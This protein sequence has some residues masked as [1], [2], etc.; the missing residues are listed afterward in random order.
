MSL[1]SSIQ[2]EHPVS[3]VVLDKKDLEILKLLQENAKLSIRDIALKIHL[4]PTPTH[5]RIKRLEKEGV[6]KQYAAL[7][8]HRMVKKSIMAICNVTM[9][10]HNKKNAKAFIDSVSAFNEVIECYNISGQYDFMLKIVAESMED[11]H[12]FYVNKLSE[13]KGIGHMHSIFVMDVIKD[14]HQVI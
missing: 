4:S 1:K 10:E 14:T 11:Y 6:I 13:I 2:T 8:N 9:S 12:R 7:L 3:A 5:E